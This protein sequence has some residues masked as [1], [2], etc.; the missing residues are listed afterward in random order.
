MFIGPSSHHVNALGGFT[1]PRGLLRELHCTPWAPGDPM[2]SHGSI[3]RPTAPHVCG[4]LPLGS[5][6]M[7]TDGDPITRFAQWIRALFAGFRQRKLPAAVGICKRLSSPRDDALR[8][9]N[10]LK[11]MFRPACFHE[12]SPGSAELL[13]TF[14]KMVVSNRLRDF[15]A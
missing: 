3:G 8:S 15:T 12:V 6:S 1:A 9:M 13:K 14:I 7:W 10:V 4:L 2:V 11:G 5:C